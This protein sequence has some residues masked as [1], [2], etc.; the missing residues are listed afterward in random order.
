MNADDPLYILVSFAG[1]R[2]IVANIDDVAEHYILL[3][4]AGFSES[5]IDTYFRIVVNKSGASWTFVC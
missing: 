2:T 4:K 5:D 1:E 3:K